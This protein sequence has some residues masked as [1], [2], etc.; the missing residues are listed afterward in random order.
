MESTPSQGSGS[1]EG[2]GVLAEVPRGWKGRGRMCQG[3]GVL[4]DMMSS[5]GGHVGRG[6]FARLLSCHGSEPPSLSTVV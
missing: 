6:E 5:W 2:G 3:S 4:R 1:E